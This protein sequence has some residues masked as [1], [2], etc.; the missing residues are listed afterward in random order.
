MYTLHDLLSK[1]YYIGHNARKINNHKTA[2]YKVINWSAL[3]HQNNEEKQQQRRMLD[4]IKEKPTTSEQQHAIQRKKGQ[5][6]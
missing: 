6:C 2:K 1:S 4:Q 3:T 5:V